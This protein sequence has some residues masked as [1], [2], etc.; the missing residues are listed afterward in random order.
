MLGL[1]FVLHLKVSDS[2]DDDVY[3]GAQDEDEDNEGDDTN[4]ENHMFAAKF[5]G[6]MAQWRARSRVWVFG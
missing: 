3:D 1:V 6:P 5:A 4:H 2:D